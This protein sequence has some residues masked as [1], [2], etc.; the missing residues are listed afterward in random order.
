MAICTHDA[1]ALLQEPSPPIDW[2]VE[3]LLPLGTVGDVFGDPSVGKSSLILDLALTVASCSHEWF[4]M[5]CAS[6]PVVLLGGERS[7][8]KALI[9]DLHRAARGRELDPGMLVFPYLPGKSGEE[10]EFPEIWRWSRALDEWELTSFGKE[11][12]AWLQDARPALIIIDTLISV[13]TGLNVIDPAQGQKLGKT[14]REWSRILQSTTLTLSHTSQASA[15][16]K[17]SSRLHWLS[18]QGSSG[19]PGALRWAMGVSKLRKD[20][21]LAAALGLDVYADSKRLI[22]VGVS[23]H[24]EMPRPAWNEIFP[25]I[26][27][28]L[29][30][31]GLKMAYDGRQVAEIMTQKVTEQEAEIKREMQNVV[32]S[33][34]RRRA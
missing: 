19:Y 27:E 15:K 3:G 18:R 33:I 26:F 10:A 25:A 24:N 17:L 9:R 32:K 1:A 34:N 11:I 29:P 14:I 6:G 4:G 21:E 2:L 23:K 22:A 16:E 31:G 13:A 20:D 30:D 28:I 5:K 12:T 7:S 8:K